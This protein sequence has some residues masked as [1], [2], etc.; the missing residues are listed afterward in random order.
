MRC[1]LITLTQSAFAQL[2]RDDSATMTLPDDTPVATESSENQPDSNQNDLKLLQEVTH[3]LNNQL[4][5]IRMMVEMLQR[6]ELDANTLRM[7]SKMENCVVT[8]INK[9]KRLEPIK[10]RYNQ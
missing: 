3:D 1:F 2:Y 10:K 4:G 9:V 5:S 8:A 6:Q 7:L